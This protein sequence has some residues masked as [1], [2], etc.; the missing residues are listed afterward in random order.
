MEAMLKVSCA[1]C[2]RKYYILRGNV[3]PQLPRDIRSG[4]AFPIEC[5]LC[6]E[7]VYAILA[8]KSKA[9]MDL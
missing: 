8:T 9:K 2:G 7:G 6:N 1:T 4:E 5:P 3:N